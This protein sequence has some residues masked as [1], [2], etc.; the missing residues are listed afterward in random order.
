MKNWEYHGKITSFSIA[1]YKVT[2][3]SKLLL[4]CDNKAA[5]LYLAS[6]FSIFSIK[7]P[8]QNERFCQMIKCEKNE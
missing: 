3:H 8:L 7:I 2:N 6:K 4:I 1:S 5:N